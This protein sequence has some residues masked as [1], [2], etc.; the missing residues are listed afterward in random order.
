MK[1][2]NYWDLINNVYVA[3]KRDIKDLPKDLTA[4]A[5]PVRN[6]NDS[7]YVFALV[8]GPATIVAPLTKEDLW[9]FNKTVKRFEK[10][11]LPKPFA[12]LMKDLDVVYF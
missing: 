7:V 8:A 5:L 10:D 6:R 3:K 12:P 1:K 4:T 11:Y 9:E 2:M